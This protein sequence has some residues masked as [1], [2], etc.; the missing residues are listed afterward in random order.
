MDFA[1]DAVCWTEVPTRMRA[2]RTQRIRRHTGLLDNLRMQK[3]MLV[4]LHADNWTYLVAFF[5]SHC[6]PVR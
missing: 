3:G 6:A 1:A 4:I 5:P 2:L